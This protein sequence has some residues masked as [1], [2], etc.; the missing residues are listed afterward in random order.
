MG[1]AAA[2]GCPFSGASSSSFASSY[3]SLPPSLPPS[4][5]L[6]AVLA[7]GVY[8]LGYVHGKAVTGK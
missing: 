6:Y 1:R 4:L 2:G 3:P 8:V 7:L 5:L